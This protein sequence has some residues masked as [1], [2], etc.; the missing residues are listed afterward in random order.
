MVNGFIRRKCI[1]LGNTLSI[2]S[3]EHALIDSAST[4][5]NVDTNNLLFKFSF[6]E[7]TALSSLFQSY[8]MNVYRK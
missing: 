2:S 8:C 4:D 1:H 5:L 6:S 3:T 7:S